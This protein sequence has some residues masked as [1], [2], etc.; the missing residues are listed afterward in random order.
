MNLIIEFLGT[1][2]GSPRRQEGMISFCRMCNYDYGFI[3]V[4]LNIILLFF[5]TTLANARQTDASPVGVRPG[6][7]YPGKLEK[8]DV[9]LKLKQNM[10]RFDLQAGWFRR[11]PINP[12]NYFLDPERCP[13]NELPYLLFTPK[14]GQKSVPM[15]LYFGGTG[16]HGTNLVDQFRQT[17][18]FN[19]LTNPEFQK[20]HPC[21]V[22]ALM[23]PK[24]G[25][26]RGG[27]P[28]TPSNLSDLVCDAM[29][30][31]IKALKSPPVDTNRL[32]LTGLSFGGGVA[33]ELPCL[34]PGRFAASLPVSSFQSALMIPQKNPGNYWLLYNEDS[35]R[36]EEGKKS[37]VDLERTVKER[38]GDF[39]VATFPEVGHNA[40]DKAWREDGVW[41]WMFSKTANRT[42]TGLTSVSKAKPVTPKKVRGAFL[43]GAVCTAS[44]SGTDAGHGPERAA[45]NLES[46][47]F[48]SVGPMKHG[49]WWMIEFPESV[50]GRIIVYSGT[51]EGKGRLSSG[52]IETSGDGRFWNRGGDF[53]RTTGACSYIQRL[54]VRFLRV[55]PEPAKP[56]ILTLREVVVED[57]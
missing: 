34:Y 48:V 38:G 39:R 8:Y 44:Q 7:G 27:M 32:Y 2:P 33:Y 14:C 50:S 20:Q 30:A 29:Y 57:Q 19:K 6:N 46:T 23:L 16:E 22:F 12:D 52:R 26:I 40:W 31:V 54:K 3:R 36:S 13:A 43:N 49:D 15:V 17:T 45:D 28:A 56:E 41:E 37:L 42:T 4:L 11:A 1:S 53:S 9:S 24:G 5:L 47:C 10:D 51:R 35:Y 18:V 25:T 21:Y 55:L